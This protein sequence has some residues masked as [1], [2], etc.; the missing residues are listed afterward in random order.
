MKEPPVGEALRKA[1]RDVA[2]EPVPE[3]LQDL[4]RRLREQENKTR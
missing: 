1:Y 2:E 3:R 4:I